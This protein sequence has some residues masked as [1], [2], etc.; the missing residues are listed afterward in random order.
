MTHLYED[1]R[2]ENKMWRE[3]HTRALTEAIHRLSP[4]TEVI[5]PRR[6]QCMPLV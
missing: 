2:P 3:E 1:G 6:G 4:E 5:V